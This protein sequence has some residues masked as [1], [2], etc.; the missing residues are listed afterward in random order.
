VNI[1]DAFEESFRELGLDLDGT[2][3]DTLLGTDDSDETDAEAEGGPEPD[4]L[5]DEPT[6]EE[7]TPDEDA[8]DVRSDAPAVEVPEGAI[9]RLPDG[10]EVEADNAVLLQSDYTKKTQ[11]VA[12][13]RKQLESERNEFESQRQQITD[14]YEQMRG[15]YEERVADPSNWVQEIVAG[16]QDPTTTIA[17]ALYEL[18]N[19]GKLD[20]QFVSTFG[21]DA[22]E[23]A[24]RA[25]TSTRDRE[26]EELRKK[27]EDRERTEAEQARIREQAARYQSQWDE[28]KQANSL[29][30]DDAEAERAAKKELLEFA[31]KSQLGHSLVDAY[32]LMTV[33]KAKTEKPQPAADPQVQ[34]KK[35]ASRAVSPKSSSS[36]PAKRRP[37]S[38]RDA[39]LEALSEFTVGA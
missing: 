15:W 5:V 33:R 3:D 8:D 23:V 36:P 17:K 19:A 18:A 4:E 26:I 29:S 35:R 22:G 32:D 25:K 20:P 34:A 9:L 28:I 13:E 37:Q 24:E 14:A 11:Q 2:P 31:V 30:F 16:T 27:V 6:A 38:T 1:E 7:D 39:A 12:E 10:T 21:I